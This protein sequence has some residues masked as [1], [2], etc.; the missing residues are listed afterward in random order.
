MSGAGHIIFN[1]QPG[2]IIGSQGVFVN[3]EPFGVHDTFFT[4]KAEN[5]ALKIEI[6]RLKASIVKLQLDLEYY[7]EESEE[8]G[9]F[10]NAISS[11][12]TK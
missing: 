9:M 10:V 12:Q 7:K 11:N 5:D 2:S 6:E 8:L 3:G 1:N 4:L